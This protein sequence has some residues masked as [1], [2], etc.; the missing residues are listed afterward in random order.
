MYKKAKN[1]K[2]ELKHLNMCYSVFENY[3]DNQNISEAN[4]P[5]FIN[6]LLRN[7]IRSDELITD[8][9]IEKIRKGN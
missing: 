9:D 8:E 4:K 5:A 7:Y 6:L 1:I 2:N 3:A